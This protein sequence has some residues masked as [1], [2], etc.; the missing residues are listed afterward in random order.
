M[1]LTT[2]PDPHGGTTTLG[3]PVTNTTAYVVDHHNQPAPVGIPGHALLGGICLA[4]HYHNR[5]DLTHER[6]TPN[7]LTP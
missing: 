3:R 6:F 1:S 2:Q 7:P 4:R 5:P